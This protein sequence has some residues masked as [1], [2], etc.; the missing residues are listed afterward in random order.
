MV[1]FSNTSSLYSQHFPHHPFNPTH[2]RSASASASD[3]ASA[4]AD[5]AS[6]GGGRVG[7]YLPSSSSFSSAF[8]SSSL[9]GVQPVH[10]DAVVLRKVIPIEHSY[11]PQPSS[12][13]AD[14]TSFAL[15][16]KEAVQRREEPVGSQ[17]EEWRVINIQKDEHEDGLHEKEEKEVKDNKQHRPSQTSM[18][19]P[20]TTTAV[21]PPPLYKARSS[22]TTSFQK[23]ASAISLTNAY[24]PNLTT[25][26][27]EHMECTTA[28][29]LPPLNFDARLSPIDL[30]FNF[31]VMDVSKSE[32]F[33]A[34][35]EQG[36]SG[37]SRLMAVSYGQP[38][39]ERK[40]APARPTVSSERPRRQH[41]ET[42]KTAPVSSKHLNVVERQQQ[43]RSHSE[44]STPSMTP[45]AHHPVTQKQQQAPM[46]NAAS[47]PP[48]LSRSPSYQST[49]SQPASTLPSSQSPAI[50]TPAISTPSSAN[51]DPTEPVM[52]TKPETAQKKERPVL[53]VRTWDLNTRVKP[54]SDRVDAASMQ[55]I[56]SGIHAGIPRS[57]QKGGHAKVYP[58]IFLH[59][60][61][62]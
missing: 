51:P 10:H 11:S 3:P 8:S 21:D 9:A 55:V 23:N 46:E 42:G 4:S 43:P 1:S 62:I 2:V 22:S 16:V 60:L 35:A 45:R 38:E 53:A 28:P 13:P 17:Q 49:V 20:G 7:N 26:A 47:R 44:Q 25:T 54:K 18:T 50:S 30:D 58:L 40:A 61:L 27:P 39:K 36:T 59:S 52:D 57:H 56:L 14:A 15:P 48:V 12:A 34:K 37:N 5:S 24:P 6:V 29:T 19:T 32:W 31:T 33:D 41:V